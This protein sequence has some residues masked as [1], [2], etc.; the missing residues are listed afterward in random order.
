M[1]PLQLIIDQ[2]S[3]EEDRHN[4]GESNPAG[5]VA[6]QKASRDGYHD[7]NRGHHLRGAPLVPRGETENGIDWAKNPTEVDNACQ[8]FFFKLRHGQVEIPTDGHAQVVEQA[9]PTDGNNHK[10]VDDIFNGLATAFLCVFHSKSLNLSIKNLSFQIN[11]SAIL[12]EWVRFLQLFL[13]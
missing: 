13:S 10:C 9:H 4:D 12:G 5:S 3:S 6:S 8:N 2:H 1:L 7:G 11:Y